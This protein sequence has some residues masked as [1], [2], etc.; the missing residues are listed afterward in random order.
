MDVLIEVHDEA[1]NSTGR[2]D[3]RLA[4]RRHQ[5]PRP[6]HLRGRSRTTGASRRG[7]PRPHVSSRNRARDPADLAGLARDGVR[8]LP[9]RREPDAPA[10]R[11]GGDP[12]SCSPW[13]RRRRGD[14]RAHPFRRGGRR[15][16]GRRRR[17]SRRPSA[18]GRARR[19][20]HGARDARA[21]HRGPGEEGRRAR[22]RAAR[23][24]HGGQAHRRPRAALPPAGA[25]QG[26]VDLRAEPA[27]RA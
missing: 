16:H 26:D 23:R 10:G 11:R 17:P 20:A 7:C 22:R 27:T 1:E 21:R 18:G 9:D 8:C 15:A 19:G 24:H 12:R 6:A 5:Q 14:E 13:R 4:A 2:S 25:H 3:A